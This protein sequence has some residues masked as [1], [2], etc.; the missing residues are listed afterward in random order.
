MRKATA[1][2]Q[3]FDE[4][5]AALTRNVDEAQLT[6][7][8]ALLN[9]SGHTISARKALTIARQELEDVEAMLRAREFLDEQQ[10]RAA[11]PQVVNP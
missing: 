4:L 7:G 9:S 2:K 8:I 1:T 5:K 10:K 11:E 3:Q 6:L